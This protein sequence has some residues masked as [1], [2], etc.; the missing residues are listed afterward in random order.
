MI[1][2][3]PRILCVDDEPE[4][5]KFLDTLLTRNGY[6]VIQARDGEEALEK[7]KEQHVDLVLSDVRMPKIDGFELCRRIKGD[8]MHLNIPVVL[9]TGFNARDDRIK[10]IESGAEDFL[11]KP[12]DPAEI[13]AR[14]KMLL[15]V[16]ALNER[17]IGDLL[18][19]MKF[20]TEQQ[21]QEAL[22]IAKEQKIKVGEALNAMGALDKDH[23]YWVLSNQ[24]NMNYIELSPEML[25]HDLLKQFP[26]DLLDELSCLPLYETAWEIHFAIADPTDQQ[27]VDKVKGLNPEKIVHLHLALPEKI[28]DLISSFK[29]DQS[30]RSTPHKIISFRDRHFPSPSA[31][32][33]P[34]PIPQKMKTVWDDFVSLLLSLPQGDTYW[35]YR[36][37]CECRL[38]SQKRD[39]FEAIQEY[40][41]EAYHLIKKRLRHHLSPQ[42]NGR[43]GRLF[44]RE[45]LTRRQEAFCLQQLDCLDRDIIKIERIPAFSQEKFL[46]SYPQTSSVIDDLHD[47]FKKHHHLL[48]GGPDP[49]LVKQCCYS[50]LVTDERFTGFPPSFFVENKMDIYFPAVAQVSKDQFDRTDLLESFEGKNPPFLFCESIFSGQTRDERCLSKILGNYDQILC[51]LPFPSME[52]MAE[53]LF[54]Q[55]G[56]EL[57]GFKPFYLDPYH[58]K[59]L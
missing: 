41:E 22:L 23:I 13:L 40:P 19:E 6:E 56:W 18:I 46:I 27:I 30:P 35:F 7:M 10:G 43:T 38:L 20:I 52:V 31:Q 55:K 1:L 37:P 45:R 24:L 14:I 48:I 16:K 8:E 21:L 39:H 11:S 36:T 29:R 58:L 5:L 53:S 44:L 51:Y 2:T 54:V 42:N 9:I 3:K 28:K 33:I 57:P 34:S 17:R 59:S 26:M 15:R 49:L 47:L 50:F 12:T 4:I 32:T 25:D